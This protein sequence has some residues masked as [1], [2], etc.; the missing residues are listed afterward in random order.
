MR[1]LAS[2]LHGSREPQAEAEA[3]PAGTLRVVGVPGSPYSRKLLSVLRYRRLP[4]RWITRGSVDDKGLRNAPGPALL[5]NIIFDD[6]EAMTD[7]TPIIGRLEEQFSGRHVY[8]THKGLAFINLI[9]ED[10]ADEWHTKHMFHYRWWFRPDTVKA[11][12][13]LPMFSSYVMPDSQYNM[14]EN[15]I[16][17]RQTSRVAAV[18]GSNDIT[19]P[20]IEESYK[21]LIAKLN[22]HFASGARFLF[23]NRPSSADFAFF[24]QLTQLA[25]FDPTPMAVI[26]ELAPRVVGFTYF[27]EDM[28]G[29]VV[30][31]E[32]WDTSIS[33]TLKAI[34][35][36]AGR[37]Y[38][39]FMVANADAI[40][41]SSKEVRTTLD[42]KAY[43]ANSFP[44]QSKCLRR[45]RASF[46]ALLPNERA[47]VDAALEGTRQELLFEEE[48]RPFARSRL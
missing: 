3:V 10:Y 46:A 6:G 25:L 11:G 35:T 18:T 7:T 24:G 36:E 37:L 29:M 12:R 4:Y 15:I 17:E 8:P 48:S 45:L 40:A 20:V 27:M 22:K 13:I 34:L 43:V 21:S 19:A 2:V 32:D 16:V 23:G 41:H 5:P 28:S 30:T 47:F 42:G 33:P 9:L 26:E 31:D 14:I 1:K 44:Y 38:A 39:P